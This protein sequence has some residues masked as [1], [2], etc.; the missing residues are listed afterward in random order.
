M[1]LLGL[2]RGAPLTRW[3]RDRFPH[4]PDVIKIY[5]LAILADLH[6]SEDVRGKVRKVVL[7]ELGHRAS[8]DEETLRRVGV[9]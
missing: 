9:Y 6:R 5:R 7:H 3:E 2:Y 4:P 8:L 1:H